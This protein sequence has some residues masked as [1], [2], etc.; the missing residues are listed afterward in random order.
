MSH[1]LDAYAEV[2]TEVEDRLTECQGK[3]N[4]AAAGLPSI[5][6]TFKAAQ[7]AT[8]EDR[9]KAAEH[10]LARMVEMV[11]I[12]HAQL[13]AHCRFARVNGVIVK[14]LIEADRNLGEGMLKIVEHVR[15]VTKSFEGDMDSADSWKLGA[16]PD[17]DE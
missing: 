12:Q 16:D 15:N 17:D 10:L 9:L 8:A 13:N 5:F 2:F 14:G 11:V 7:G 4:D 6:A 1:L 3:L